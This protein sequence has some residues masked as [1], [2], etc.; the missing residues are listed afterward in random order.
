MSSLIE[1]FLFRRV[2]THAV[3]E[4]SLST[5][6]LLLTLAPWH[7]LNDTITAQFCDF[8]ITSQ[9]IDAE[10]TEDHYLPW[11]IIAFDCDALESDR[12]AFCL[13]CSAIEYGFESMW[14][15]VLSDEDSNR[16]PEDL[17]IGDG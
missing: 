6:E 16:S 13:H 5:K 2:N 9:W 11:D 17:V 8:K 15:V 7:D 1:H 4:F 3:V 12:W 10:D 14:P